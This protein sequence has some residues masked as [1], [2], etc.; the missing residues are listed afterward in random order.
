MSTY[1]S[2]GKGV[3]TQDDTVRTLGSGPFKFGAE[4]ANLGNVSRV[5]L[6][7]ARK[8]VGTT[9]TDRHHPAFVIPVTST[10][11]FLL[12][13]EPANPTKPFLMADTHCSHVLA[14]RRC[15]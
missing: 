11:D 9:V 14:D 2:A 13:G 3:K 4:M 10:G 5:R 6:S 12:N 15:V 7:I 1:D 8:S